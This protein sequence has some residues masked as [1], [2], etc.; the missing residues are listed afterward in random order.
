[1]TILTV[2]MSLY[3]LSP[4]LPFLLLMQGLGGLAFGGY[5]I[6]TFSGLIN[7]GTPLQRSVLVSLFNVVS[8]LGAFLAPSSSTFILDQRG[9]T[10]AFIVIAVFRAIGALSIT[11]P[12]RREQGKNLR[13]RALHA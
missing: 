2:Q 13:V 10:V 4:S 6:S 9:L 3:L 8:Q 12:A 1:M 7:M 11:K 5:N